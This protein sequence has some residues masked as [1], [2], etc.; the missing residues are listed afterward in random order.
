ML[1]RTV[2]EIIMVAALVVGIFNEQKLA[3]FERR[4]ISGVFRSI[5]KGRRL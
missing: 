1:I 3:A 5:G 4:I 2:F